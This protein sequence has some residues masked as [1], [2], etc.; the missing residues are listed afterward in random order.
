[1]L[2]TIPPHQSRQDRPHRHLH[3]HRQL[4]HLL[5]SNYKIEKIL[6]LQCYEK[7]M[8][9]G[10]FLQKII[11]QML[12]SIVLAFLSYLL[13]YHNPQDEDPLFCVSFYRKIH[14]FLKYVLILLQER[15]LQIGATY[16]FQEGVGLFLF[17]Q[18]L[19]MEL[20]VPSFHN[21][22]GARVD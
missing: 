13:T 11:L 1:M 18:H 15:F 4:V 16:C 20:W 12:S 10:Y 6:Y 14:L 19:Q 7:V 22:V 21:D 9:F 17:L 8:N 2:Q 3:P 5:Y